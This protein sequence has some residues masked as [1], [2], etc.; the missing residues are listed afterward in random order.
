MC[1]INE[2]I[3]YEIKDNKIIM[4][5]EIYTELLSRIHNLEEKIEIENATKIITLQN[6][7]IEL[8]DK[9]IKLEDNRGN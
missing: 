7:I 8:Y 3:K 6:K 9:I 2:D 5:R 1:I 4:D